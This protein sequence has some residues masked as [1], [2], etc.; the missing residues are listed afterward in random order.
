MRPTVWISLILCI[1]V[2][3]CSTA[4]NGGLNVK[5]FN[6]RGVMMYADVTHGKAPYAKDPS[7]IKFKGKYWMYYSVPA[8]EGMLGWRIGIATSDDLIVWKKVGMIEPEQ[9]VEA[10][11]FCA[12]AAIIL[13]G[14]INIFYQSYGNKKLDAI[15]HAWSE[16]G[17]NFTR[18]P[19]NPIFRPHG[20]WTCGRA[21]DAE[22]FVDG[23]RLLLYFASR[24]VSYKIQLIG[25]ASAPLNSDLSPSQWTQLVDAPILTPTLDWEK[26]CIE[27]AS[28]IKRDNIFY[29][30][31]AGAYNNEPQQIGVAQSTDG[32]KWERLSDQPL[33]TNGKPGSWNSSESGHPGIFQ[34]TDGQDYLFYQGNNDKGK[35]WYLSFVKIGWKDGRPFVI[36]NSR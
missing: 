34:D 6:D 36:E 26:N 33:L 8:L 30:F 3:G 21:I 11:G 16:D 24:D 29:M 12:P 15:C 23:D 5:S 14:K 25:V 1:L 31:Y 35:T 19:A 18:N 27:A 7:V 17:I 10:N 22:A 13:N 20:D 32:V 28:I 9:K 2:T 4:N